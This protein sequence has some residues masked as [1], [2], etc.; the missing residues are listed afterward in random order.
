[1]QDSNGVLVIYKG[2]IL[3]VSGDSPFEQSLW[4]IIGDKDNWSRPLLESARK[5][6]KSITSLNF[7]RIE[8]L[9]FPEITTNHIFY[10]KLTDKSVNSIVRRQGQRLEFYRLDEAE[11]L[12]TTN[13]TGQILSKFRNEISSLLES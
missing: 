8:L 9:S 3:L 2:K 10:I 11:K 6:L 4:S 5:M 13:T 1:M 12:N 7:L